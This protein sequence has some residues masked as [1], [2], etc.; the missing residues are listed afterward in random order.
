M[1]FMRGGLEDQPDVPNPG[2]AAAKTQGCTCPKF[3]N[4]NG[5]TEP[6]GGWYIEIGCPLHDPAGAP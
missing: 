3:Q 2:S 5:Q 1:P 4:N 6:A